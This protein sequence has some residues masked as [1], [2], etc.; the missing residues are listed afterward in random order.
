MTS[1]EISESE[2]LPNRRRASREPLLGVL[3]LSILVLLLL[4]LAAFG[5]WG[6][7]RGV[8]ERSMENKKISI[9]S[10]P[11]AAQEETVAGDTPSSQMEKPS[12]KQV[13]SESVPSVNKKIAIK[14]LNGGFVKGAAT[15]AAGVL[16]ESG[17]S[18]VSAGN[19]NGNYTGTTV[20]FTSPATE[21][22]ANAVKEALLKKYPS[23]AVKPSATGT[24][25]TVAS[26][27]T[28]IVG[29]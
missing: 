22:D 4:L 16:M 15:V 18:S 7:Y 2:T 12:E 11:L 26:P 23:T 28:V 20:Y 25:D 27:V 14:V 13:S 19:A 1:E 10:M 17:Y 3:V 8:K 6:L 29:K 5:G 9:E 21:A 24:P